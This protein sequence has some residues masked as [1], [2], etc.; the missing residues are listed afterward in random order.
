MYIKNTFSRQIQ[1]KNIAKRG[2]NLDTLIDI[3]NF[4]R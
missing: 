1:D 3:F 4:F 2:K